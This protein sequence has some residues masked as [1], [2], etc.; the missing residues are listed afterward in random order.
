MNAV[1]R[2]QRTKN[3]D[4]PIKDVLDVGGFDLE[5][6]LET[7]PT[8]LKPEYP[9]EWAGTYELAAG[10]YKLHLADGPDP[11]MD[12]V[13]LKA[14]DSSENSLKGLE[15]AAVLSFSSIERK[16]TPGSTLS[17]GN[18]LWELRLNEKGR[19]TFNFDIKENG[20]FAF[21]LQHHP[22]EF[23]FDL[24]GPRGSQ[25]P[26]AAHIYNPEHEHEEDVT[27]VGIEMKGDLNPEKFQNWISELL[28]T[29]GTDIFRSK[30]V[31]SMSGQSDRYI[32][33]GVHMLMDG[34]LERPWGGRPRVNQI[35]F[36]GR[37]LNREELNKG[38]ERCLVKQ[39]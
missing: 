8:F 35:V 4:V 22:E 5:R 6:A 13:I 11:A 37:N 34:G 36:I 16:A 28:R 23:N 30:G 14:A 3:A 21:F 15:K 2:I 7:K 27:S 12:L 20:A 38:F 39:K 29:K 33:Q 1:A 10:S 25:R 9:F 17:Y 24:V 32:F 19:K 18:T 31:L 26:K